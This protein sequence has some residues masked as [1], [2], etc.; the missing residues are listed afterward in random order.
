MKNIYIVTETG[1][2][3]MQSD[4]ERYGI[5][6]VPMH[7]QMEGKSYNDGEFPVAEIFESYR[8]T[9]DLPKTSATSPYEY[10]EAFDR[11]IAQNPDAQIIHLAYSAITTA[12]YHNAVLAS[13]DMDNVTH[14]DTKQV[15]GGLRAIVV[16]MAKFI[17]NNPDVTP[18]QLKN[19]GEILARK[20]KFAFF[21]GDLEYLKAGGRVSNAAYLVASML[22]L[23]PLIEMIDGNLVGGRQRRTKILAPTLGVGGRQVENRTTLTIGGDGTGKNTRRL[24]QPL[25]RNLHAEGV[26]LTLQVALLLGVPHAGLSRLHGDHLLLYAGRVEM[27]LDLL[28]RRCPERKRGLLGRVVHLANRSFGYRPIAID[29]SRRAG[30]HAVSQRDCDKCFHQFFHIGL[31]VFN[32]SSFG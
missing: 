22:N 17:E 9:K 14:I 11:I 8:R 3:L 26:L 19:Y 4:I 2:D 28:G 24:F 27:H 6:V 30:R 25:A 32:V 31:D 23:K 16:K 29:A 15:S 18:Q 13:N 21:P 7:V 5:E 12:S 1:G 20:C 10:K